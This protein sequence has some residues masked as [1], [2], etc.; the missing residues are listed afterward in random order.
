MKKNSEMNEVVQ[1]SYDF[2]Q[3]FYLNNNES[4]TG[5]DLLYQQF[6][7]PFA[8]KYYSPLNPFIIFGGADSAQLLKKNVWMLR[9]GLLPLSFFFKEASEE[10]LQDDRKFIIHKDLWFLVP[11]AWQKSV[12]FF[13]V[14]SNNVFDQKRL[15]QKIFISGFANDTLA[16]Q[17]E[18]LADIEELA[19]N[20]SKEELEK[21]QISAYFPGKNNDLWAKWKDENPFKYAKALFKN[22]KIDIDFPDW[23]IIK[24][25]M[26]YD[27]TLY[28]EINRG[29]MVKDSYLKQM[30]LSRGAG[31]LKRE[32]SEDGFTY[33]K[34]VQLSPYHSVEILSCDFKEV[35]SY[36][37][38]L[39]SDIMP[40]FKKIFAKTSSPRNIS[41]GWEKWYGAYIKKHYKSQGKI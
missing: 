11:P 18:F 22:L 29:A 35:S 27:D 31:E 41:D 40:Y 3:S 12:L 39:K 34:N 24:S 21:I 33:M 37:D 9:D 7:A 15:P 13:D 36:I 14:K 10:L 32:N 6:L 17:D 8:D 23:E 25:T 2:I 19:S 5:V 16:D 30:F 28:F 20:F 38:P 4:R 1:W 26:N